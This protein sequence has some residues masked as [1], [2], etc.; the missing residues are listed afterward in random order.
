MIRH[1]W[2]DLLVVLLIQAVISI[3]ANA[4]SLG[5][6]GLIINGPISAGVLYVYFTAYVGDRVQYE[7]MLR[8]FKRNF[9]ELVLAGILQK[10]IIG[11]VFICAGITGLVKAII[12]AIRY[13]SML[14]NPFFYNYGYSYY[15]RGFGIGG[16]I[17][18][19]ITAVVFIAAVYILLGLAM[20]LYIFVREENARAIESIKLSWRMM[21]G[22]KIKLILFEISFIGWWILTCLTLGILGI[23]TVPYYHSAKLALYEDIYGRYYI[24]K[25]QVEYGTMH[26]GHQ[27][28]Y[29]G[30]DNNRGNAG[31]AQGDYEDMNCAKESFSEKVYETFRNDIPEEYSNPEE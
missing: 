1:Q 14:Y 26:H 11:A 25:E 7:D 18:T 20:L 19:I 2:G 13:S 6:A 30:Y 31:S 10:L 15:H 5:I 4:L 12:T 28:E 21:K 17:S 22:N 23:W 27:S 3:V 9:G 8:F 16:I 29:M 24:E